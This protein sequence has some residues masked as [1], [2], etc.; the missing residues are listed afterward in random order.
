VNTQRGGVI[1]EA[2]GASWFA[3]YVPIQRGDLRLRQGRWE[4]A[5][6]ELEE[7]IALAELTGDALALEYA[8]YLLGEAAVMDGRAVAARDRLQPLIN[9]D[10]PY[11]VPLLAALARAYVE[12]DDLDRAEETAGRALTLAEERH[13]RLYVP[14]VRRVQGMI[15]ARQERWEGAKS[16]FEEA[17]SLAR[18]MSYPY[19]EARALYEYG[20]LR[21][22]QGEPSQARERLEEAL[23]IFRQLG[24]GKDVERT[25]EKLAALDAAAE[26]A[27]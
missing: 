12:V 24:A 23:A 15:L 25:E 22:R 17:I 10:G 20:V 27:P 26:P 14:E 4:E 1:L 2:V 5:T 6:L 13:Q 18:A 3:A 19:A 11:V 7:A 8:H 16:S 21:S 9:E